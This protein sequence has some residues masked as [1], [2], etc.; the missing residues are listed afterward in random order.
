MNRLFI[1]VLLCAALGGL[2]VFGSCDSKN[3]GSAKRSSGSENGANARDSVVIELVGKDSVNVL[4][5]LKQSHQVK[6]WSTVEGSFVQQVDSFDGSRNLFWIYSVN[7]STPN[8]ASDKYIT[9]VGDR[10]QWHFR[11]MK[12][13]NAG[14]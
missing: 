13:P 8:I 6:A 5:L 14:Q 11:K 7:D 3:S 12:D 4:D 2:G 10:V 1:T 9:H